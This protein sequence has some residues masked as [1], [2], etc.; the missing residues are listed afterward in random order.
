MTSNKYNINNSF[1]SNILSNAFTYIF[2][3]PNDAPNEAKPI[4]RTTKAKTGAKKI[5]K[6]THGVKFEYGFIIC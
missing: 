5:V 6:M 3:S 2:R 1:T 4:T